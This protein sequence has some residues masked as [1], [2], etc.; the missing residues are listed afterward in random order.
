MVCDYQ[1]EKR[2]EGEDGDLPFGWVFR[3]CGLILFSMDSTVEHIR[4]ARALLREVR[5]AGEAS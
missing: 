1:V 3:G 2:L 5:G 4:A